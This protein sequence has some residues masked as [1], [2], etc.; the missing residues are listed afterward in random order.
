MKNFFEWLEKDNARLRRVM[1]LS[2]LAGN[3]LV[4]LI[5]LLMLPYIDIT[6]FLGFYTAFIGLG[7]S[8][9][10]FYT[11]TKPSIRSKKE[12]KQNE[13]VEKF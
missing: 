7:M 6:P 4:T 5:L 9:I 10:G 1:L 2:A 8:A 11:A 13:L 3:L 12:D